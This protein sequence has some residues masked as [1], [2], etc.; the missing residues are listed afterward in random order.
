MQQKILILDFGS[1]YTHLIARRIREL[2]VYSEIV[3]HDISKIP[4]GVK[5]III[6]GGPSS[7]YDR[8]SPRLKL[9]ISKLNIPVLGICYGH[10]LLAH[11]LGGSVDKGEKKEYGFTQINLGSSPLFKDIEPQQLVWESHGDEV[12][13]VPAGFRI[14]ASSKICGVEAMENRGKKIFGLQF[15]P[16]V[17]HTKCGM[18]VLE[19]FIEIASCKRDWKIENFVESAVKEVKSAVGDG[20]AI[21]GLSGG[22]D[23][24]VAAALCSRAIGDNLIAVLVDHGFMRQ[25]EIE[26]VKRIFD[27]NL[28]VVDAKKRFFDRLKRVS[29]P[30]KKRKIIGEEFVRVFE[31]AAK[32][33]KA[34]YLIQGTI[35]PDRIESGITK[36]SDVIKTHHNVGGLPKETMFE[37]KIIEPLRD[38]YKDEVRKIG[39]VL[40]VPHDIVTRQPFPGPGLAVRVEGEVTEKKIELIRKIDAIVMEEM[41]NEILWQCF[42]VLTASKSTGVKGDSRAF[43]SV[44]VIRAVESREAM[45]ARFHRANWSLLE[46]I[47]TRI[48]NECPEVT[49]VCYDITN[50]PPATIEWE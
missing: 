49:R 38:L 17:T 12:K 29:D 31:E 8:D 6:S 45:T 18:K 34:D 19:N 9:D 43:G 3:P 20:K 32:E 15:H 28:R 27:L 24:S 46:K 23:S 11:S 4:T 1:Q 37:G 22:V 47:S 30:E 48:T 2:G 5:A 21:I 41:R 13:K 39:T 36:K 50:K 26:N 42:P 10:Q 40:G 7:V 44:V 14:T 16:E 33:E 25:G 35:Y